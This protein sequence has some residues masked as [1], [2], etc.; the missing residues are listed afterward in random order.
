[1]ATS[2]IRQVNPLSPFLFLLIS[3]VLTSLLDRLY[4]KRK[5]EGFKVGKDNV[6]VPLLQF[7]DDTLIFCKFE[8]ESLDFLRKTINIYEWFSVEKV[9]WEKSAL[10]GINIDEGKVLSAAN[11]LCCKVEVLPLIYLG[12]PW[13]DTLKRQ[14]FGN[15]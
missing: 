10:C 15:R 4:E 1:M 3:E 12:L 9:N 2:G 6:H 11:L 7:A 13:V 8:D 5:F 14:H